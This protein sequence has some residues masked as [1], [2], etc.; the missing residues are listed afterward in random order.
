MKRIIYVFI[1]LRLPT[2]RFS[3]LVKFTFKK[4]NENDADNDNAVD[5]TR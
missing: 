3:R 2:T 5:V 4:V 1:I